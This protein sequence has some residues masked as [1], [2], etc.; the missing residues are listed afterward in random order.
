MFPVEPAA[1]IE[2]LLVLGALMCVDYNVKYVQTMRVHCVDLCSLL[3]E[4][5]VCIIQIS[6]FH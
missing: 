4:I 3:V 1:F 5:L 2:L 6:S